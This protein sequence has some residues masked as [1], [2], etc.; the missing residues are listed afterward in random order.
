[1]MLIKSLKDYIGEGF[2]SVS[3]NYFNCR[4]LTSFEVFNDYLFKNIRKMPM[5]KYS[6]TYGYYLANWSPTIWLPY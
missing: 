4:A 3:A 2:Y 1:M 6:T 5:Y